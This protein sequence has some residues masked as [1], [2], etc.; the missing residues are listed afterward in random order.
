LRQIA[1]IAAP[2][3][4]LLVVQVFDR[5]AVAAVDKAIKTADL[6]LNPRVDGN[7]LRLPI[8]PLTEERRRELVKFA[9]KIAE[10]GKVAIRNIRRDANEMIKELEKEHE[11]SEDESHQALDDIQK[12]TDKFITQID[13]LYKRKEKEILNE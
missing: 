10:E 3:P 2:D 4:R 11:I 12:L 5:N 8:P 6:G 1:N 13:D 9:H 7:I